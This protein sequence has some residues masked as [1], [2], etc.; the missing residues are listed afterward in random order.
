MRSAST[1]V[2]SRPVTCKGCSSH[3]TNVP[4]QQP[5]PQEGARLSRPHAHQGRAQGSRSTATQGPQ[6]SL[7]LSLHGGAAGLRAESIV[8]ASATP[9][10]AGDARFPRSV[11]IT[12]S[13]EFAG[14]LKE[15]VRVGGRLLLVHLRPST[16]STSRLGV[17]VSR[18]VGGAVVRNRV[19]RRLRELFRLRLRAWLDA[20]HGSLDLIITALPAAAT[21]SQAELEQDVNESFARW[22]ARGGRSA[23]PRRSSPS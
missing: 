16:L 6:A 22:A 5:A 4:T 7:R 8:T 18:R 19:R 21:A 13:V 12:R 2:R 1:P 20:S 9:G 15:G 14:V 23:R 17:T 10:P 3:E 11:R